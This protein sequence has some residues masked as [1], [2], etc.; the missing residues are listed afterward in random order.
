[1]H[2]VLLFEYL[3]YEY[4]IWK[5]KGLTD[6]NIS[7][8]AS[9]FRF[10]NLYL[11]LYYKQLTGKIPK[12]KSNMNQLGKVLL[13]H[14][15]NYLMYFNYVWFFVYLFYEYIIW[16]LTVWTDQNISPLAIIVTFSFQRWYLAVKY[17]TIGHTSWTIGKNEQTW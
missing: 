3:C 4:I 13:T 7:P 6:Q 11:V 17:Q 9:I 14:C 16:I 10:F 1:M 12:Y 8:L 5:W 2:Y 15:L